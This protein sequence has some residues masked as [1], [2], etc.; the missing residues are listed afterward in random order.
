MKDYAEYST[1]E[2]VV[3][4]LIVEGIFSR[5][6]KVRAMFP[7]IG[8]RKRRSHVNR[9]KTAILDRIARAKQ[10]LAPDLTR[11]RI[12]RYVRGDN[13]P[14]DFKEAMRQLME[15]RKITENQFWSKLSRPS[16]QYHLTEF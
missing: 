10:D 12:N 14:E 3:Q 11:A 6:K 15:E 4:A 1:V 7:G 8:A 2:E 13:H 5:N 16:L 9:Y